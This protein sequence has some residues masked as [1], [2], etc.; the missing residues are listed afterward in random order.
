MFCK[1]YRDEVAKATSNRRRDIIVKNLFATFPRI[2]QEVGYN[3]VYAAYDTILNT[4]FGGDNLCLAEKAG[5]SMFLGYFGKNLDELTAAERYWLYREW[6]VNIDSTGLPQHRFEGA[7][8]HYLR[9][10]LT[11]EP[12]Y[13]IICEY[14]PEVVQDNL[15]FYLARERGLLQ[16]I[17]NNAAVSRYLQKEYLQDRSDADLS[18]KEYDDFR[19]VTLSFLPD[20]PILKDVSDDDKFYAAFHYARENKGDE[21]EEAFL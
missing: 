3:D 11:E 18:C 17:V 16:D 14:Q 10:G 5:L 4:M 9:E 12:E 7:L 20:A 19:E 13:D 21:Y 1:Q 2:C 6:A 15:L 8:K